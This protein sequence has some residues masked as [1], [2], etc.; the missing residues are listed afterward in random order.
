[1]RRLLLLGCAIS[2]LAINA[3][4][5]FDSLRPDIAAK[6][7][8]SRL[9]E[10]AYINIL[11][12]AFIKY[13]EKKAG[14]EWDI[15]ENSFSPAPPLVEATPPPPAGVKKVSVKKKDN[16]EGK[17]K[18]TTEQSENAVSKDQPASVELADLQ[19][20]IVTQSGL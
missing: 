20:Q 17:P 9:D 7:N 16:K 13:E 5:K 14:G 11:R 18:G 3:C 19:N 2:V 4:S 6:P 8:P 1:M 10:I 12:S 15:P